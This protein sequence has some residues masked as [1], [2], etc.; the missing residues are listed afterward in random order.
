MHHKK[1]DSR[2]I[3]TFYAHPLYFMM[4]I[5]YAF[6]LLII[7]VHCFKAAQFLYIKPIQSH[8]FN[9]YHIVKSIGI[10]IFIF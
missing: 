8:L 9:R 6:H 3:M 10:T 2:K 1:V 7:R 5:I 4:V